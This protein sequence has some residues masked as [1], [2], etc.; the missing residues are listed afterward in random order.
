VT[1]GSVESELGVQ[2]LKKL[3]MSIFRDVG[4]DIVAGVHRVFSC[5]VVNMQHTF[6]TTRRSDK[7]LILF[8]ASTRKN[9]TGILS[10]RFTICGPLGRR[11]VPNPIIYISHQRLD[12][13][14]L[15]E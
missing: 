10:S 9:L 1:A 3:R 7:I 14:I 6:C 11:A 15:Q 8:T 12:M 13:D 5:P 2:P 4:V